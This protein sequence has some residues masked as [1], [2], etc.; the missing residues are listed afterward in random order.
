MALLTPLP[1]VDLPSDVD[2]EQFC[3]NCD[4]SGVGGSCNI[5]EKYVPSMESLES[6]ENT[7]ALLVA[8][9]TAID[10]P[11]Y[12]RAMIR[13]ALNQMEATAVQQN[14]GSGMCS[15][16]KVNGVRGTMLPEGEFVPEAEPQ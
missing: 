16:A 12:H 14:V 8:G 10:S 2:S 7:Q 3:I 15:H 13:A 5:F 4:R 9:G 11:E 1:I 6:I